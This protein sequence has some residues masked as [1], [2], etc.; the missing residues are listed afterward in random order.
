MSRNEN[1]FYEKFF[2][3]LKRGRKVKEEVEEV[4]VEEVD[5]H[6]LHQLYEM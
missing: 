4:E 3:D 1:F 6:H 5:H 2:L